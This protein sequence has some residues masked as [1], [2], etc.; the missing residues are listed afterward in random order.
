[1]RWIGWLAAAALAA[2]AAGAGAQ[3][4]P[5][6][7]R[8]LQR[9]QLVAELRAL[10][11]TPRPSGSDTILVSHG[12]NLWDAERFHLATH[13]EAALYRP[14]GN[15]GYALVARLLPEEWARLD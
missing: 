3:G 8:G 1:V 13:G 2:S 6:S 15:G 12:L 7:R 14:D 11:A 9:P 5:D 4:Q 10:L